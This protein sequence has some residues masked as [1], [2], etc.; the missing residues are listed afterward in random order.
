MWQIG[1][2]SALYDTELVQILLDRGARFNDA[3]LFAARDYNM[4]K[5]LLSQGAKVISA[6]GKSSAISNAAGG[7]DVEVVRLLL[8]HANDAEL[9]S[10]LDAL[11]WA[12]GG[13]HIEVVKLLIEHGFDVNVTTEDPF[14]GKTPLLATCKFNRLD[15]ERMAVAKLLIKEGADVNARDQNGKTAAELLV[16]NDDDRLI[17]E[18]PELQQLLAGTHTT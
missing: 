18:D 2:A 12:A 3:L 4:A 6:P 15:P 9:D 8:S 14:V 16:Q 17:Q 5:F 10:S 1:T 11:N 13:G 7:G